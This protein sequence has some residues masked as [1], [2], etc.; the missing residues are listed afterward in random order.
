VDINFRS[1]AARAKVSTACL[2]GTKSVRDKIVK[3]RN[4]SPVA[5]GKNLQHRQQ[6]SHQRVVAT[7]RLRIRA[8]EEINRELKEQLEAA[9]GRL[10]VVQPK[11]GSLH[12]TSE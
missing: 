6:L 12:Q 11:L 3:I 5:A 4:T 1:V 7:L 8:L 9:Y 10:A 2:Y